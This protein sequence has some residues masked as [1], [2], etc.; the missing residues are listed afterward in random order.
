MKLAL[1][2]R[3]R[4]TDNVIHTEFFPKATFSDYFKILRVDHWAKNI[5][6]VP[7][8]LMA[9][10]FFPSALNFKLIISIGIAMI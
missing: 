8:I 2:N 4:D 5:F 9:L 3:T 1:K 10:Y 7:G 6:V